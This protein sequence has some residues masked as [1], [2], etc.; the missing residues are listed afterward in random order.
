MHNDVLSD[1]RLSDCRLMLNQEIVFHLVE[2][3]LVQVLASD[4]EQRLST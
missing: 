1:G 2:S 3:L 4:H